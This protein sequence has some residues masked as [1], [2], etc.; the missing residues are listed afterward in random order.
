MGLVIKDTRLIKLFHLRQ[1][2][3]LAFRVPLKEIQKH[4][5]GS[6]TSPNEKFVVSSEGQY[7]E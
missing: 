4:R 6:T 1:T 5:Q 3:F 7:P 2:F